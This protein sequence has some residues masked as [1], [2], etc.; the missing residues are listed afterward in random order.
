M[1]ELASLV[2][3]DEIGTG[4]N[5]GGTDGDHSETALVAGNVKCKGKGA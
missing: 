3:C 1:W 5:G 2:E 4:C